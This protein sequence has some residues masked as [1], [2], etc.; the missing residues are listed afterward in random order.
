MGLRVD[1]HSALILDRSRGGLGLCCGRAYDV[2]RVRL[3][4][5][6]EGTPGVLVRVRYCESRGEEAWKVG[7][8]FVE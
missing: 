4:D 2:L 3:A 5:D 1:W 7:C 8:E 6:P